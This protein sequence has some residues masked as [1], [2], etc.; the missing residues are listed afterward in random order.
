MKIIYGVTRPDSGELFW[1]GRAVT[2]RD[3]AQPARWASAW[4]SSTSRCSTP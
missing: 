1:D 4:C 2:V 3:P